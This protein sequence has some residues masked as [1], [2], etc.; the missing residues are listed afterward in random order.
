M[1]HGWRLRT[2]YSD[3]IISLLWE[4]WPIG[5]SFTSRRL[6]MIIELNEDFTIN[7]TYL[8]SFKINIIL[9][10]LKP[11]VLEVAIYKA[12]RTFKN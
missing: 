9:R 10:H 2:E 11:V 12:A 4:Y 3:R 5:M 6:Y 1:E 8:E 7:L